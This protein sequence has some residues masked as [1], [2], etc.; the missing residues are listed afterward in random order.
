MKNI[1]LTLTAALLMV[2]IPARATD[3]N[4]ISNY[5]LF[6][7]DKM[8]YELNLTEDQYEAA[9][10]INYDYLHEIFRENRYDDYDDLY[11]RAW[12][13]RNRDL[14][15]VLL[16]TQYDLFRSLRY[17]YRPFNCLHGRITI[18][19]Y[20]YYPRRDY[21][22]FGCPHFVVSYRGGHGWRHYR[23]HSY[24]SGRR[25]HRDVCY[26][27]R[28]GYRDGHR[29]YHD[30]G[31]RRGSYD[32]GYRPGIHHNIH[33]GDRHRP[34]YDRDCYHGFRNTNNRSR[35]SS[36]RTTV[37]KADRPSRFDGSRS[38]VSISKDRRLPDNRFSPRSNNSS[39]RK[40]T[41]SDSRHSTLSSERRSPRNNSSVSRGS[42]SHSRSV[43]RTTRTD[44]RSRSNN[45]GNK[46]RNGGFGG[47]R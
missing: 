14:A 31:Y 8:A 5:A 3:Y 11:G 4:D 15:V 36:T 6:L 35:V 25:W 38:R 42:R 21:L 41:R 26:G 32:N 29:Y 10:E 20:D 33:R 44:N 13:L 30:R 39:V 17:F 47:G 22:Y 18:S 23:H 9:Y 2:V 19:I 28:D 37:N 12:E 24:Y 46:S 16:S 43:T 40:A 27:M 34:D 1:I 45:N 7:T